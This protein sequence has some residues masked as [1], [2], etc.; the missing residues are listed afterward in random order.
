M[1][2][3]RLA[4]VSVLDR[5]GEERLLLDDV[6][7]ELD[8]GEMVGIWGRRRSGRTTLLRIAGGLHA[9]DS[10]EVLFAGQRLRGPAAFDRGIAYCGTRFRGGDAWPVQREIVEVQLARG[11]PRNLARKRACSALERTGAT[12]CAERRI[13]SMPSAEAMRA[14]LALALSSEPRLLLIDDVIAG[15]DLA[16]RDPM[17]KLLRSLADDGL[18][19]LTSTEEAPALAGCD[20]ALT[21]S[22]GRLEGRLSPALAEV[23]PLRRAA[24]A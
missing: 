24:P 3:L 4:H 14:R 11:V 15:V 16:E 22:E 13:R 9:V 20:R 8:A 5:A 2:L 17:L 1:S 18:A 23:V 12:H 6:C 19:I 10:G 21:L 7:L